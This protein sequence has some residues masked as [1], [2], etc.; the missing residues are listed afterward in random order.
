MRFMALAIAY[1]QKAQSLLQDDHAA[2]KL[3]KAASRWL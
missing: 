3:P 2:L 1:G